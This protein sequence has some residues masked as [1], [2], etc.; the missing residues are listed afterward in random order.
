[1]GISDHLQIVY[2]F[3]LKETFRPKEL[4]EKHDRKRIINKSSIE[5]FKLK[6]HKTSCDIIRT[7]IQIIDI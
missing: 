5:S 6:L 3:K 2:A 7:K 4:K 1:M